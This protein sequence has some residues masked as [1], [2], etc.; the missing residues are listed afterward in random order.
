MAGLYPFIYKLFTIVKMI[1]LFG[2][3]VGLAGLATIIGCASPQYD[4]S[5][6]VLIDPAF[7][8]N[9]QQVI[10]NAL[11]AWV[12]IAGDG[13]Y[14]TFDIGIGNP[15]QCSGKAQAHQICI[16][17]STISQINNAGASENVYAFTKPY[18]DGGGDTFIPVA[19]DLGLTADQLTT[20][21]AHEIGH[22][23]GLA[24]TSDTSSNVMY[25]G[26]A[27]AAVLP[28]CDDFQQYIDLRGGMSFG[29]NPVCPNGGTYTLSDG[30]E[31][32][33]R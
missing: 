32:I 23:M 14:L 9:D 33:N 5:Y 7:S 1:K 18:D 12:H 17:S 22:A 2:S 4:L 31:H 19:K 11:D 26:F 16:H 28:T 24:H 25:A 13:L 20:V 30:K 8:A 29:A 6:N 15:G 27:H 10:V 3:L 21:I